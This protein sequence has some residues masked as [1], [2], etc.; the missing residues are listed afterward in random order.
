MR[1]R[2]R[3]QLRRSALTVIGQLV[4]GLIG[5]GL[6][7]G[8]IVIGALA[9][10]VDPPTVSTVT[11]YHAVHRALAGISADDVM[12]GGFRLAVG[13]GGLVAAVLFG[14]MARAQLPAPHLARGALELDDGVRGR[15]T[16]SPRAVERAA[17]SAAN[18]LPAVRGA[19][20]RF[21]ADAMALDVTLERADDVA[22]V[23]RSVRA[24]AREALITHGLPLTAVDVTLTKFDAAQGRE[25]D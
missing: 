3:V 25:L 18:D 15:T 12:G 21:G 22:G 13:V 11:G 10:G 17:E 2:Q 19:A 5:L 14:L 24:A 9:A 20:G 1:P 23:L 7:W 4:A 8:A 6:L 16:V